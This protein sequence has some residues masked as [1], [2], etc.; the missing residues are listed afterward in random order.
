[1][2]LAWFGSG[3][4]AGVRSGFGCFGRVANSALKGVVPKSVGSAE[5]YEYRRKVSDRQRSAGSIGVLADRTE[6]DTTR[7]GAGM[8]R[9]W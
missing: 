9:M 6:L 4:E 5:K 8:V 2:L 7:C 1:M 3:V